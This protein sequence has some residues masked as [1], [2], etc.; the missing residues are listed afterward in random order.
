[1][2]IFVS[3]A[4]IDSQQ[5]QPL[6]DAIHEANCP[7]ADSID[8]AKCFVA[9]VTDHYPFSTR[10]QGQALHAVTQYRLRQAPKLYIYNPREKELPPGFNQ[11]KETAEELPIDQRQA[12]GKIMAGM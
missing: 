8:T 3:Y 2:S 4:E 6:L 9:V 12:M 5:A 1:M 11:F 7:M 10:L